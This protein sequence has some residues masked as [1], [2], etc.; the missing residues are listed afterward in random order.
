MAFNLGYCEALL[1]HLNDIAKGNTG[2][3]KVTPQGFLE[4]LCAST[5]EDGQAAVN[6]GFDENTGS[7]RDVKFMYQPRALDTLYQISD[8]CDVQSA[9]A[10]TEGTV[11][12]LQYIQRG[13]FIADA[14][15]QRYCSEYSKSLKIGKPATD[16][17]RGHLDLVLPQVYAL[18]SRINK[19]LI[20][21]MVSQFGVNAR[22][23]SNA[24]ATINIPQNTTINNLQT[25]ITQL[26][27]DLEFNEICGD[28]CIVGNGLFTASELQNAIKTCCDSQGL[29]S[30]KWNFYT[31]RSDFATASLWGTNQLGVFA[32]GS[33]YLI[34][35]NRYVGSYAGD[36]GSSFFTT[37]TPPVPADACSML[38]RCLTLDLQV[39]Y[40]DCPQT[41]NI[42]GV[43]TAV[44]RGLEL[45]FS[46]NYNLWVAPTNQYEAGDR[47]FGTNGTLRYAITNV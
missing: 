36:R 46:S 41:I 3:N 31:Y 24:P 35:R 18:Y 19:Q 42:D 15:M 44:G 2:A 34:T 43:A 21:A 28:V 32:K 10:Y 20:S 14:Q 33:I 16:F 4:T 40:L 8:N 1:V 11:P 12:S 9:P 13:V 45:I 38:A 23:G 29:D 26:L 27:Y 47:L 30:S 37:F 39:R 25:G 5:P 17:M 6:Q 22:T 7:F